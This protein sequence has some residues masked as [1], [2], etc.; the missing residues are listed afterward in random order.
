MTTAELVAAEQKMKSQK[1]TTAV[2]VGAIMG[3]AVYAATHKKGF[4]LTILLMIFAF[5]IG[6]RFTKNLQLIQAE[7]SRRN[8]AG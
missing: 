2:L 8:T 5:L 3:I 4:I 1:I 6:S 7:I